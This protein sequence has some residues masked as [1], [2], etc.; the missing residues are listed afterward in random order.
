MPALPRGRLCQVRLDSGSQ[1]L[2][3]RFVLAQRFGERF[4]LGGVVIRALAHLGT[5]TLEK[6]L[7]LDGEASELLLAASES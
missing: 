4:T 2:K 3:L 1:V 6:Q 7:F 5:T